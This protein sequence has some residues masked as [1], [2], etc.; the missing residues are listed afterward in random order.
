MVNDIS[1]FFVYVH[2]IQAHLF[3]EKLERKF[4]DNER[5]C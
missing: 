3:H 5:I 2:V 1:V 4:F